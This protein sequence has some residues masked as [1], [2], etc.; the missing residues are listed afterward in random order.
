MLDKL[1]IIVALVAVAAGIVGFYQFPDIQVLLRYGMVVG[2][3]IVGLLI[4]LT[5]TQGQVAWAFITGARTEIRKVVWP[6]RKDTAQTTMIVLVMVIL[7]GLLIWVVDTILVK[8]IYGW[9][10]GV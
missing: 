7:I 2:G 5:S 10:L 8:I 9:V 4:I 3:V 1:K 6:T